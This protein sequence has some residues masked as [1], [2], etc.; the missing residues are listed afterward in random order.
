[1]TTGRSWVTYP[2]VVVDVAG[3]HCHALLDTGA[4]SSS[5]SAALL[6]KKESSQ[7]GR[8]KEI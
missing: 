5:A 7:H 3:V 8:N 6:D 1:M 4:G 2:V